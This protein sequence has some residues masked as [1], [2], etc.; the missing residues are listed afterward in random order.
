MNSY[1]IDVWTN[2]AGQQV[3][4]GEFVCEINPASGKARGAFRYFDEYL[5]HPEAYAL[6]PVSL[7]FGK[8]R[9][10]VDHP[11]V[12]SV[13]LD[14]LP[15]D[16]GKRLLVRKH[17][18]LRGRQNFPEMLLALGSSG[19][20]ALSYV[21][22]KNSLPTTSEA[23]ILTLE[24]L[25]YETGLFEAGTASDPEITHLL[26]AGSSPGGAR[27]KALV[28][29][30][31]QAKKYIAKFPS[32]KDT[33]DVVR[34]EAATMSLAAKAGLKVA[35]TSLTCCGGK[36][37]L[38]VERFDVLA[39]GRRH[40]ISMQT[41][42]KAEGYYQCRYKDL[43]DMVRMVSADPGVD[44]AH[45][46]RQMVF[47]AV[48]GNTDDHLKN[49]WMTFE[50]SEGWRL[51]PAFDLLPDIREAREHI[52]FFDLGGYYPGRKAL[53]KLGRTWG[54]SKSAQVLEEVYAALRQWREEFFVFGVSDTD[55]NRFRE[56]D[57]NLV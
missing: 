8:N 24:R 37:V 54:V 39:S 25:V 16:W 49:F 48:I 11:G 47:N 2:I 17:N 53:E 33:V 21:K 34:I 45:L 42:L 22:P 32:S 1:L 23:S 27:P 56:I 41:L 40:M 20:G 35:P 6:D 28:Q 55:C 18:L 31:N 51:S 29:D 57:G 38:L 44:S 14:S 7:P 46:F 10:A 26:A 19:L 52:L 13:F 12:F 30:T 3:Q 50:P 9:Y 4:A 15:D 43:L 36:S 5:H